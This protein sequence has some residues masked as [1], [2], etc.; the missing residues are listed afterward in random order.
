MLAPGT[1]LQE[2][3]PEPFPSEQSCVAEDFL[4]FTL[5]CRRW[6]GFIDLQDLDSANVSKSLNHTARPA[7]VNR[8]H[9]LSPEAE[10]HT[11]VARGQIASSGGYRGELHAFRCHKFHFGADSIPIGLVPDQLQRESM[12]LSGS[13]VTKNVSGAIVSCDDRIQL[14]IIINV[15]RLPCRER[16]RLS[17]T[18]LPKTRRRQQEPGQCFA[19][20]TSARGNAGSET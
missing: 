18:L 9:A 1:I 11:F 14:P 3:M 12:V 16:P 5:F 13:L 7:D 15:P 20:A 2:W 19:P 10:M 8:N 17:G 6:T 4:S